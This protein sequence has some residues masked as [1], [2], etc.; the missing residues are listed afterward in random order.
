MSSTVQASQFGLFSAT[1]EHEVG[2]A[3]NWKTLDVLQ[4]WPQQQLCSPLP[5]LQNNGRFKAGRFAVR[6]SLALQGTLEDRWAPERV[7]KI[8]VT[9]DNSEES[10]RGS[11]LKTGESFSFRH[12]I[13]VGNLWSCLDSSPIRFE[14]GLKWFRL[15]TFLM[16]W[17]RFG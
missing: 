11:G 17:F 6:F 2:I 3:S 14:P 10:K 13:Q 4:L 12:G 9:V 8:G 1:R 7:I 16:V 5:L 15:E